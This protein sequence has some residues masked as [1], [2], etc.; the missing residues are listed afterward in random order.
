MKALATACHS[1]VSEVAAIDKGSAV[2]DVGVVV[3]HDRPVVPIK[4]PVRPA[5]TKAAKEPDSKAHTEGQVWT[6]KP[7][8]WVGVPPWPGKYRVSVD[9]PRIVCRHIDHFW[10]GRLDNDCLSLSCYGLLR[11]ALQ[12][13]R[14]LR[15]LAQ[16]LHRIHYLLLLIHIR[17]AERRSPRQI[18][19]HVCK[20]GRKLDERFDAGIP[21]LLVYLVPQLLSFEVGMRLNPT[22]CFD[23][24][25][26]V[27]R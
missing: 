12:I 6:V 2:R 9:Q 13:S 19:I 1:P 10:I 3:V 22:I 24:F 4:S 26:R 17:I 23:H 20:H 8:S 18:F 25:S 11:S 5:P 27:C 16:H 15:S 14:V 21:G 7:N